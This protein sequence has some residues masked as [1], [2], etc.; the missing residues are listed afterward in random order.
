MSDGGKPKSFIRIYWCVWSVIVIL[1]L[2]ARFSIFNG[3]SEGELGKLFTIYAV[4]TWLVLAILNFYEGH[5]FLSYLKQHHR[6]TW[7]YIT[8]IPIFGSGNYNG[9]RTLP[10]VYSKDDLGD[11]V[12]AE[13]KKNLRRF[14]ILLLV[15]FFTMPVLF[16]VV[17]LPWG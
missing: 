7:E 15:V 1:L 6:A 16:L 13:L 4:P 17:V 10:F 2:A 8:Y 11:E 9:F 5:R 3:S 12:V 14:I